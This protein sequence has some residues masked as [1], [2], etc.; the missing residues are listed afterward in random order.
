[1]KHSVLVATLFSLIMVLVGCASGDDSS[2]NGNLSADNFSA[3]ID[4][5]PSLE[6]IIGTLGGTTNMG[7]LNFSITDQNPSGAITVNTGT[8]ELKVANP[9][10]F[11]FETNQIITGSFK[12]TNGSLSE[13]A[14]ISINVNDVDETITFEGNVFLNTQQD[15]ANFGVNGVTEITGRLLIGRFDEP[16]SDI[17]DVSML[18]SLTTVGEG[19]QVLYNENLSDISS[20]SNLTS[21]G[22][23]EIAFNPMLNNLSGLQNIEGS[24][25]GSLSIGHN[26]LMENIDELHQITEVGQSLIIIFNDNLKNLGGLAAINHVQG[27]ISIAGNP[28]LFDA[29]GLSGITSAGG[30]LVISLNNSLIELPLFNN[31]SFPGPISIQ[32]NEALLSVDGLS[33]LTSAGAS[34][35]IQNNLSLKD[36]TGLSGFSTIE[37]G[38]LIIANNSLENLNGLENLTGQV[39]G[40]E[41]SANTLLSDFCGIQP[42]VSSSNFTGPFTASNNAYDPTQ[43]DII[44]GN[45]SL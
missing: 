21:V 2:E 14:S 1:M 22:G 26:P 25:S 35:R 34:I 29:Q 27:E 40:L 18:S 33:Q 31:E 37:A 39:L 43:Q 42:L 20:L 32:S 28:E 7:S 24:L 6:Q 5:N 16:Y 10:L 9:S 13:T 3:F 8:G 12:V 17:T 41:F 36:L 45:C 19:V 38:I 44:D 15:V 4:E 23:I 11:D 30:G